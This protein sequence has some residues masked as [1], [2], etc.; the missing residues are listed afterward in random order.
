LA[1]AAIPATVAG[2]AAQANAEVLA[3]ITLLELFYPG[4]PT[5]YGFCPTMM[6]LRRGGVAAGGP[7]DVLLQAVGCQMARFYG[8]PASIGTFATGA[9]LSDWHAGVENAISGVVSQLCG[10]DMMSGAGLLY[11]ARIFSFEQLL[12]DCEIYEMLRVVAQGFAIDDTC[13]GG[14]YQLA[15]AAIFSPSGPMP[16]WQPT[17]NRTPGKVEQQAAHRS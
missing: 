7:E 3:G 15:P 11:G 6:D 10:A 5:F 8:I 17:V 2:I 12:L 16:G 9:K 1:W 4:T 13:Y 14:D